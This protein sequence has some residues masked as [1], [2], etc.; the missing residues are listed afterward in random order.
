MGGNGLNTSRGVDGWRL[1]RRL[2]EENP[3]RKD[4]SGEISGDF[5]MEC[6]NFSQLHSGLPV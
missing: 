5:T 2:R 6:H 1:A 3:W 4:D